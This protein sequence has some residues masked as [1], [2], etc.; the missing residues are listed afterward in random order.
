M[1]KTRDLKG[2]VILIAVMLST[3]TF[4]IFILTITSDSDRSPSIASMREYRI[5][6]MSDEQIR[7]AHVEAEKKSI[8]I[9]ER[10]CTAYKQEKE[11]A[12]KEDEVKIRKKNKI[13]ERCKRDI[14]Y[15]ERNNFECEKAKYPVDTWEDNDVFN[16]CENKKTE[17]P[18][19]SFQRPAIFDYGGVDTL[20][21]I[22]EPDGPP[23]NVE[24][25]YNKIIMGPCLSVSNLKEAKKFK[26]VPY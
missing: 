13:N 7:E 23:W 2:F 21:N 14:A 11:K 22:Q 15:K 4:I 19:T 26:C 16:G 20:S 6:Q 12:A 5:S 18:T 9:W 1:G 10:E 25:L 3:I 17:L 8:E 24:R